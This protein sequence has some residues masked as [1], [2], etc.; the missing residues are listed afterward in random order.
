MA[1]KKPFQFNNTFS[2][3][4]NE[5]STFIES[6]QQFSSVLDDRE[7]FDE[8]NQSHSSF[9]NT[10]HSK[11]LSYKKILSGTLTRVNTCIEKKKNWLEEEKR[12]KFLEEVSNLQDKPKIN[13]YSK[14]LLNSTSPI[15]ERVNDIMR[16]KRDKIKNIQLE[17]QLKKRTEEKQACTFNPKSANTS[18]RR[19]AEQFIQ[20]VGIWHNKKLQ[21]LKKDQTETEKTKELEFTKNPL[22]NKK[23]QI[24]A[25]KRSKTPVFDRLYTSKKS[26]S[27]SPSP[28]FTPRTYEK[29]LELSQ[30]LNL[31]GVFE[32]LYPD[33]K[34]NTLKI[35]INSNSRTP[36][37]EK[38][39]KMLRDKSR[40]K[41]AP[42]K[43]NTGK[44]AIL[45]NSVN[46]VKFENTMRF[47]LSSL[48]Q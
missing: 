21:N 29:S 46:E 18:P 20:Q 17:L 4:S 24:L 14:K 30:K 44:G 35:L 23:S 26:T 9:S 42:Y 33:S 31:S 5:G 45:E 19:T 8:E 27:K 34:S 13:S 39:T 37:H 2:T 11:S 43:I 28:S 38:S 6:T 40:E 1:S 16:R 25:Q 32:R 36:T 12:K 3:L 15:H 47:L 10:D 41:M 7:S 22:I 48:K